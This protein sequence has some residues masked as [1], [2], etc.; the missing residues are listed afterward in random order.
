MADPEM[1]S[2][3]QERTCPRPMK[4]PGTAGELVSAWAPEVR[5]VTLVD[6]ENPNEP[7]PADLYMDRVHAILEQRIRAMQK[8]IAVRRRPP[9]KLAAGDSA[10]REQ[11]LA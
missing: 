1:R 7:G 5:L 9:R 4:N 8:T 10:G 6:H 11:I 3:W 2:A